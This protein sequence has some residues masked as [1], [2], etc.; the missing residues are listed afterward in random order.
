[1]GKKTKLKI[2]NVNYMI[3]YEEFVRF[4]EDAPVTGNSA[5]TKTTNQPSQ[6]AA[7]Q[8][9][10]TTQPKQNHSAQYKWV[11][12]SK[13]YKDYINNNKGKLPANFE[14]RFQT[15]LE[16]DIQSSIANKNNTPFK[17]AG[18]KVTFADGFVKENLE[19]LN[20]LAQDCSAFTGATPLTSEDLNN[21]AY[22]NYAQKAVNEYINNPANKVTVSADE[23]TAKFKEIF[24]N[25][26]KNDIPKEPVKEEYSSD[27]EF[28]A[29]KK[30]H[31]VDVAQF[32]KELPQWISKTLP[33]VEGAPGKTD[34]QLNNSEFDKVSK[35]E[36]NKIGHTEIAN[37]TEDIK[38]A[39]NEDLRKGITKIEYIDITGGVQESKK[40]S[41]GSR[42]QE[43][44]KLKEDAPV[45]TTAQTTQ[46]KE[47]PQQTQPGTQSAQPQENSQDPKTSEMLK[48]LSGVFNDKPITKLELPQTMT[49]RISFAPDTMYWIL[50]S[51]GEI[52]EKFALLE[53]AEEQ[54]KEAEKEKRLESLNVTPEY[55]TIMREA[56]TYLDLLREE[57][58]ET[59]GRA[60]GLEGVVD[61]A[62]NAINSIKD[63]VGGAKDKVAQDI[64]DK[65]DQKEEDRREKKALII[66]D[67]KI[68]GKTEAKTKYFI[69][70]EESVEKA[71][72]EIVEHLQKER[73]AEVAKR[74][75][76]QQPYVPNYELA[77]DSSK[78]YS[79]FN[80]E[81]LIKELK[82]IEK[83][84]KETSLEEPPRKEKDEE[85]NEKTIEGGISTQSLTNATKKLAP[86]KEKINQLSKDPNNC[87]IN[88][89]VNMIP[90]NK[91]PK[92]K[93]T[94]NKNL[95]NVSKS[96]QK[97]SKVFSGK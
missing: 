28:E 52:G 88:I 27:E 49:F 90:W 21:Q 9:Q 76:E 67:I 16:Q 36:I 51:Y 60:K 7:T 13:W 87:Q 66:K 92:T 24:N 77:E 47:V 59:L 65:K 93:I 4:L 86:L 83:V 79:Y 64:K 11:T 80:N 82:E 78:E 30:Q 26:L 12:S 1:V 2:R 37:H 17:V 41:L 73:E 42:I 34:T 22:S 54:I 23:F 84:V 58:K 61:R 33:T 55:L 29:A 50:R 40:V 63:K 70:F 89:K 44:K 3:S 39:F 8:S 32:Y 74:P 35:E 15:K 75:K 18:N 46:P 71:K 56:E 45:N 31:D 6:Q 53:A 72:E 19:A 10:T 96:A 20:K 94:V 62:E 5:Q 91:K 81:N 68:D 95:M 48:K 43:F 25:H 57:E 97:W 85:G 14:S 69:Q 38:K